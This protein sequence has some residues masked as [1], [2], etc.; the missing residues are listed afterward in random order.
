[1][2][3]SNTITSVKNLL[4]EVIICSICFREVSGQRKHFI[5]YLDFSSNFVDELFV[6]REILYINETISF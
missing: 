4:A 5:S 3:S 6:Y 1:M 2:S